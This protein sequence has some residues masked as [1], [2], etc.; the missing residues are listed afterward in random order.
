MQIYDKN[1]PYINRQTLIDIKQLSLSATI[2]T[3]K[4]MVEN[5]YKGK[6]LCPM[7]CRGRKKNAEQ[8]SPYLLTSD[9]VEYVLPIFTNELE[10]NRCKEDFDEY[11]VY[12]CDF[13]DILG[14]YT[15]LAKSLPISIVIDPYGTNFILT[16]EMID[17]IREIGL[18]TK[19]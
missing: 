6:F 9:D 14:I 5:I 18:R 3:T 7:L 19:I 17:I 16:K 10:I 13:A 8:F 12:L 2:D 15:A 1:R 11:T 4:K